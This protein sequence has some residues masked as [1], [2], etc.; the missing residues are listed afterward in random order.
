MTFESLAA[1]ISALGALLSGAFA[2]LAYSQQRM[3]RSELKA[4]EKLLFGTPHHPTFVQQQEHR[5]SVLVIAVHNVSTSKRAFLTKLRGYDHKGEPVA[6]SWSGQTDE[7]GNVIEESE[8]L[9]IQSSADVYVRRNDGK[10]IDVLSLKI[11]H[12]F[13]RTAETVVFDKYSTFP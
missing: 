8:L 9:P 6:I 4:D 12:T 10:A 3:V 2:I 5:I 11:F 13:S 7:V 1:I